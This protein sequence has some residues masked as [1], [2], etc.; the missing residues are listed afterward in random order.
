MFLPKTR[1]LR[2]FFQ[3]LP[4]ANLFLRDLKRDSGLTGCARSVPWQQEK[5]SRCGILRHQ[6]GNQPRDICRTSANTT[7]DRL[8]GRNGRATILQANV[9]TRKTVV[10]FSAGIIK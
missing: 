2:D 8:V 10:T 1:A 5:G 3:D 6:E 7:N 9:I 4:G